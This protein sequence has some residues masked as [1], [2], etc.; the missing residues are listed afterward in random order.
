MQE[1]L[2]NVSKG[3]NAR[4]ELDKLDEKEQMDLANQHQKKIQFWTRECI[5]VLNLFYNVFLSFV[6]L[7]SCCRKYI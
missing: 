2:I 5:E 1:F 4:L 7:L 6:V 3:L